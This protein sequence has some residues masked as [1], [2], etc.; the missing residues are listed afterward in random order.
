MNRL[1]LV[2]AVVGLSACP[3]RQKALEETCSLNSDCESPL[4]CAFQRCHRECNTDK[5][6][7]LDPDIGRHVSCV[8]S[9][10][11]N[12]VCLLKGERTC[13][14][15]TECPEGLFCARDQ[16]CR[17]ACV[18]DIDC[19][20][21]QQCV[22]GACALA[23]E[24]VDGG[25]PVPAVELDAGP[26]N[27]SCIYSSECPEPLVCLGGACRAECM[28]NRDCASGSTCV[29][30]SC[31]RQM[32]EVDAGQTMTDGGGVV[33]GDG[34]R[35]AGWGSPCVLNSD[36]P[37]S[38]QCIERVCTFECLEARDCGPGACCLAN[39][40]FRGAACTMAS[41]DAGPFD[42]GTGGANC[43][44]DLDCLATDLR[45]GTGN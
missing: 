33:F 30:G 45:A 34:G 42:A 10:R 2:V 41:F 4:V 16:R 29:G 21:G 40:C 11:P 26:S 22:Q 43:R 38:L 36:C 14:Y 32:V 18:G 39:E 44:N 12:N 1:V 7:P 24:V 6:C 31:V 23:E 35:P 15:N 27:N 37:S 3:V 25:L 5:D 28:S 9:D 13:V 19:L 20:A 17:V 8:P